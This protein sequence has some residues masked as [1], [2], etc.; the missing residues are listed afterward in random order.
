MKVKIVYWNSKG[1]DKLKKIPQGLSNEGIIL[2]DCS[3]DRV[4]EV[5][6]HIFFRGGSIE[7]IVKNIS[8]NYYSLESDKY[9]SAKDNRYLINIFFD[10][11]IPCCDEAVRNIYILINNYIIIYVA[12]ERHS[13]IGK[14]S[15][16]KY[17]PWIVFDASESET[18]AEAKKYLMRDGDMEMDNKI[19]DV[20]IEESKRIRA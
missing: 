5:I 9:S 12:Y 17:I 20:I 3:T 14:Y 8:D 11:I 1:T 6:K 4:D 7:K 15:S 19:I 16:I 13:I 2:N 18:L 10:H